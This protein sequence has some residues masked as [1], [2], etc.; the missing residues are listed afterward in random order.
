MADKIKFWMPGDDGEDIEVEL[1]TKMEVC[2]RCNGKGTHVNEAI[3]GNG[4]TQ[5]DREDWADDDFMEDYMAGVY[6]VV[7]SECHGQN[8]VAVPDEERNSPEIMEAYDEWC[9][10]EYAYRIECEEERRMGA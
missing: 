7:C 4:I 10:D 3:D 5:S 1:K 9:R 8:V 6:D 2:P